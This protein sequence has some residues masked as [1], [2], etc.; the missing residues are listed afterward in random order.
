MVLLTDAP[1]GLYLLRAIRGQSAPGPRRC[2][3]VQRTPAQLP[4]RGVGI[5]SRLDPLRRVR[6]PHDGALSHPL[7]A[8]SAGLPVPERRNRYGDRRLSASRARASRFATRQMSPRRAHAALRCPGLDLRARRREHL[9]ELAR[10]ARDFEQGRRHGCRQ[11]YVDFEFALARTLKPPRECLA[12][13][14]SCSEN[15]LVKLGSASPARM[16]LNEDVPPV[17]RTAAGSSKVKWGSATGVC[18]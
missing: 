16:T 12:V 4:A 3:S 2:P 5:A 9:D 14:V 15:K 6:R 10:D 7:R 11:R 8:A 18:E 1:L 17:A 13:Q